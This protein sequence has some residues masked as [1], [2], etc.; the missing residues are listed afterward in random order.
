MQEAEGTIVTIVPDPRDPCKR[1][2]RGI[3][4]KYAPLGVW[5]RMDKC[6][7]APN[8]QLL[9]EQ[10]VMSEDF[11]SQAWT[12]THTTAPPEMMDV[13]MSQK[14][15][16]VLGISCLCINIVSPNPNGV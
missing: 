10:G 4:L 13:N 1:T 8:S 2:L 12:P 16:F 6:K 7:K 14:L 11:N 15:I 9:Q 3:H 5:V